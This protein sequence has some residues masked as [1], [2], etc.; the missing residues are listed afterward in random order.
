LISQQGD[1]QRIAVAE[2]HFPVVVVDDPDHEFK[3]DI[4]HLPFRH[5]PIRHVPIRHVRV[6]STAHE[7]P[8]FGGVAG[9]D[10][11]P[12]PAPLEDR[13]GDLQTACG[14][15]TQQVGIAGGAVGQHGCDVVLQVLADTRDV[16]QHPNAHPAQML[17]GPDTGQHQ[18]LRRTEGAP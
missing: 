6:R 8:G 10:A 5:L 17:S 12:L 16:T 13:S 9:D 11:G 7:R 4:R 2:M 14:G 3:L 15:N 18:D 1:V